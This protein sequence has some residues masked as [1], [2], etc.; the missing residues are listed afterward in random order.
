MSSSSSSSHGSMTFIE[1]STLSSS[2]ESVSFYGSAKMTTEMSYRPLFKVSDVYTSIVKLFA[3]VE[4]DKATKSGHRV[5][6]Q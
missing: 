5:S 3:S 6:L 2:I 4:F 1:I